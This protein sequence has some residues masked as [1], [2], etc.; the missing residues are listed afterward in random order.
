MDR[1]NPHHYL[2][3]HNDGLLIRLWHPDGGKVYFTL[4]NKMVEAL[5]G[6]VAGV[7]EYALQKKITHLEYRIY[8]PNGELGYDPYAFLPT[9]SREDEKLFSRGQHWK[10]YD[11]M[12]GRLCVHQ[13]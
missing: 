7:F 9:F 10:L 5:P 1:T 11:V 12:G 8:Y 13:G 6:G 3:L 4:H 2:G